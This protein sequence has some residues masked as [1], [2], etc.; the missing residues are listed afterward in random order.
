MEENSPD[1]TVLMPAYNSEKYIK[2]AISSIINQ[3]VKNWELLIGNDCSTD[4]TLEILQSYALSDSRIK[5]FNHSKNLGYLLNVNF[6][7]E[8]ATGKYIT[9]Q[10]SDDWSDSNRLEIQQTFLEINKDINICS[11]NYYRVDENGAI[12]SEV[13]VNEKVSLEKQVEDFIFKHGEFPIFAGGLFFRKEVALKIGYYNDFFSRKCGEDWDWI[14]RALRHFKITMLPDLL[15]YYRE[16][17]VGVTQSLT[18]DKLINKSL[19]ENIYQTFY[20]ENID[21]LDPKYKKELIALENNLKAP[22]LKDKSLLY[23]ELTRSHLY[24]KQLKNALKSI[25]I[26][27]KYRPLRLKY[28]RSLKFIINRIIGKK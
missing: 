6:L 21:L 11:V 20:R 17:P 4:G 9:F 7:W 8:K 28:Y 15:Y 12:T 18:V 14:L 3:S 10:D 26:A 1:I 2:K 27:I 23:F 5:I 24:H 13:F 22:Y 19:I 25:L 16:N